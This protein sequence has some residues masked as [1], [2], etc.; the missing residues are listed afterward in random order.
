MRL[1]VSGRAGHSGTFH[2]NAVDVSI[3]NSGVILGVCLCFLMV[4]V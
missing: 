1:Q 2:V 4:S 3:G